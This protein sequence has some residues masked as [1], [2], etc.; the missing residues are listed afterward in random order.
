MIHTYDS[1]NRLIIASGDP[2]GDF[3]SLNYV[4]DSTGNR[5][6]LNNTKYTYNEINKLLKQK[7]CGARY[8]D[9]AIERFISRD[10]LTGERN[11]PQTL[12]RY[13]YCLNNPLKYVDPS[14]TD[15]QE[16]VEE[17]FQRLQNVDLAVLEELQE[18]VDSETM[19]IHFIG[20]CT[21]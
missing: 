21:L 17:I 20:S 12:N 6:Q 4:Y 3:Y 19:N 10:P 14:G 5:I 9:P 7:Y 13:V 11:L 15:P 2:Q 18:L 1:L 8:Y 16:A